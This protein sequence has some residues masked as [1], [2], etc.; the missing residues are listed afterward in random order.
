M[1]KIPIIL[2]ILLLISLGCISEQREII[3]TTTATP[4][5]LP[6][7]SINYTLEW[8]KNRK[9]EVKV[10][11]ITK[12][13]NKYTFTI[14]AINGSFIDVVF[15]VM[16]RFSINEHDVKWA[17]YKECDEKY[18]GKGDPKT[19][20]DCQDHCDDKAESMFMQS[21]SI[22]TLEVATLNYS[23][24][25]NKASLIETEDLVS[26]DPIRQSTPM[27]TNY[28]DMIFVFEDNVLNPITTNSSVWL[29]VELQDKGIVYI[30]PVVLAHGGTK[31]GQDYHI[32]WACDW[33]KVEEINKETK[34]ISTILIKHNFDNWSEKDQKDLVMLVKRTVEGEAFVVT[35]PT[36]QDINETVW[37]CYVDIL[38]YW[39]ERGGQ[40]EP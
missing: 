1:D 25:Y 28:T 17:C 16:P 21:A 8:E 13:N 34:N 22:N 11:N 10:S 5:P 4:T 31:E 20:G 37:S 6:W 23:V 30:K 15:Y 27:R 24:V 36:L 26:R 29:S 12:E 32:D 7:S 14:N 3:P 39:I 38:T 19:W 2:T 35:D 18:F 9:M 40:N 33:I